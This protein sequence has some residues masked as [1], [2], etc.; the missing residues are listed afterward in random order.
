MSRALEYK[1]W[2]KKVKGIYTNLERIVEKTEEEIEDTIQIYRF[3]NG[4]E[5]SIKQKKFPSF[6]KLT[7]KDK[8]EATLYRGNLYGSIKLSE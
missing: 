6:L 4:L 8:S 2:S 3:N 5:A 1:S 7:G